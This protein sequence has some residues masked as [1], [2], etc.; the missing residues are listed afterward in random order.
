MRVGGPTFVPSEKAGGFW[1]TTALVQDNT[2]G[3]STSQ[4]SPR[5]PSGENLFFLSTVYFFY[6]LIICMLFPAILRFILDYF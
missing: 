1:K 3:V 6:F 5:F 2:P 4:I